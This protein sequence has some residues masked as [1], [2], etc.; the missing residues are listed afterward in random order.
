MKNQEVEITGYPFV[1]HV[2]Q[3]ARP[4][5]TFDLKKIFDS[6]SSME[7]QTNG[8]Y[9]LSG[10]KYNLRPYLKQYVYRQ[11]G[12]WYEC[13]SPNKTILRKCIPGKIDK[14]VEVL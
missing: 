9:K 7:I 8:Y 14:I 5:K 11:Y 10:Y 4:V 2:D 1:D 6:L 3:D 13:Y 12:S